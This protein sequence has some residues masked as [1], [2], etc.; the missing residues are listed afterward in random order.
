MSYKDEQR[1]IDGMLRR[2]IVKGASPESLM[3][4]NKAFSNILSKDKIVPSEDV[5]V[6]PSAMT[7]ESIITE[8]PPEFDNEA[9][10]I[11]DGPID[12]IPDDEMDAPTD[13]PMDEPTPDLDAPSG[14]EEAPDMDDSSDVGVAIEAMFMTG[15]LK[16]GDNFTEYKNE[17][18]RE[19]LKAQGVS[20]DMYKQIGQAFY[21][22]DTQSDMLPRSKK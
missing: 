15:I 8:A 9:P 19:A 21:T 13:A 18:M 22:L 1:H 16:A 11:G 2:G 17:R 3:E 7:N 5:V 4:R 12:D 10:S 6:R 14:E 20:E